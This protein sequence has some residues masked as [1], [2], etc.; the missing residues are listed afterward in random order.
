MDFLGKILSNH[1]TAVLLFA[2]FCY[3]SMNFE[4]SLSSI[5]VSLSFTSR[6]RML[7]AIDRKEVDHT[8]CSF[9]LFAGLWAVS[10]DYLAYI[11]SQ[12]D[13]GLDAYVQIPPRQPGLMNDTYNL[14]GLPVRFDPRVQIQEWTDNRPD[15]RY[16]VLVKVYHTPAGSL[17]TEVARTDDWR[18]GN[19]IPFLDDYL[20]SRSLSFLVESSRDLEKLDY[21][22]RPPTAEEIAA[23]QAESRPII[24]FAHQKGLLL[25]GGWGVGADMIGWVYGL[26]NMLYALYDTPD[27]IKKL[28]EMVAVWNRKRMEVVLDA[29]IDLYIKRAW[30]ENC[31]FWTPAKYRDFLA[32][33]LK[34]EAELAHSKGARFGYLITSNV[35]PLLETIVDCGVDVLIGVDPHEW[36]LEQTKSILN[37]RVA[38]WGGING[39][40]TVERESAAT[41][42]SEV[43]SAM[44]ILSPGGGFILSPVDNVRILDDRARQNVFTLIEEWQKQTGQI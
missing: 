41:V 38:L 16:P 40:L 10:A 44:K 4:E 8:P 24:E 13:M 33:I 22:L 18:W 32:P 39:H 27:F 5:E 34:E 17:R 29:G 35:K 26:Q 19:H 21:L 20:S 9:M 12:L 15:Q 42:R 7:A 11:Q 23:F 36:D 28:L 37:G 3:Y 30:Y 1:S 31:D 14:H 2:L 25:T 6:Q 43:C